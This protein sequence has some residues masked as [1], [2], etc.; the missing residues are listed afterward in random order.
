MGTGV[1][2]TLVWLELLLPGT[3]VPQTVRLEPVSQ[4]IGIPW[5]STGDLLPMG[6]G[7]PRLQVRLEPFY[8]FPER[9]ELIGV[10]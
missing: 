1:S 10:R 4:G 2:W 8:I 9:L 7:H 6:T 5:T 3:S